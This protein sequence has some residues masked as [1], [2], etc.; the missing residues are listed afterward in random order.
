TYAVEHPELNEDLKR[1]LATGERVERELR[2]R[3]NRA[4]FL[5]I[6]PYRAKGTVDGVVVTLIDVS[7]LQ[8]AEDALFHERYL[9]NSLLVS[10]PDAIY[11]K[12]ARGRFIRTNQA[13]ADR[14][15]LSD[16][17]E[18]A[19]KTGFELP[20]HETALAVHQQDEVVLRSGEAQH[21]RLEQ[22]VG[23]DGAVEWDLVTRLP[24]VNNARH[25]VGIIG[26]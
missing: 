13:M 2:D 14:L 7:G 26:I 11:V 21:Y 19:G 8:A 4:F 17:R 9:L 24:L 22:R 6:L 18:A 23:K 3:H 5:R 20:G 15:G 25:I 16:P 12:D 1:V 10:V